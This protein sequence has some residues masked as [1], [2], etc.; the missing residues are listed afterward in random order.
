MVADLLQR[1]LL[2]HQMVAYLKEFALAHNVGSEM[3]VD[4]N[5]VYSFFSSLFEEFTIGRSVKLLIK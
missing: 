3:E 1:M 5:S 2:F 4:W